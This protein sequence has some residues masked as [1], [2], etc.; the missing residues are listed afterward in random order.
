M[1]TNLNLG[2]PVG[3]SVGQNPGSCTASTGHGI[4]GTC[5]RNREVSPGEAHQLGT[6]G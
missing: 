2:G 5:Q 6:T 1:N 3:V 4:L